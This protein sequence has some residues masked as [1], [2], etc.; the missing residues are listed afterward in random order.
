MTVAK[1]ARSG[2]DRI[3]EWAPRAAVARDLRLC[4]PGSSALATRV[5]V[6]TMG[7]E[8]RFP[9]RDVLTCGRKRSHVD[10]ADAATPAVE[11]VATTT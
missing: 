8:V 10:G 7:I 3:A 4:T 2:A 6:R 11:P 5:A 9:G 1:A